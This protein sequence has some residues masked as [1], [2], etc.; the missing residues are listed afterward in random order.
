VLRNPLADPYLLGASSGSALLAY[1]WQMP[2]L[3]LAL[4]VA[5]QAAGQQ[6]F[7]FAGAALSTGLTLLIA[8]RRGRLDPLTLLLTGIVVSTF[9]GSLFTLLNALNPQ[10]SAGLGGAMAFLIGDLHTI[11]GPQKILAIALMCVGY[12]MLALSGGALQVLATGPDLAASVGVPVTRTRWVALLAAA[13]LVSSAMILAGPLGFV[14][15]VAPHLVRTIFGG[16]LR[17]LLPL[18]AAAGAILLTLAGALI[19]V[20]AYM[21][22]TPGLLPLGVVTSLL[23]G[24]FFLLLLVRSQRLQNAGDEAAA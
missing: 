2:A 19:R 5:L 24:P 4:P 6:S 7:A 14:G 16:D 15:L 23:G 9:C 8:S 20:M 22:I 10:L 1:L 21:D 18:S 11:S 3:A 12:F 17:T 13:L